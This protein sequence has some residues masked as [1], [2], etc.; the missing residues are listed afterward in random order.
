MEGL[1]D[2]NRR[3]RRIQEGEDRHATGGPEAGHGAPRPAAPGALAEQEEQVAGCDQE[4]KRQRGGPC[5]QVHETD[6]DKT[7]AEPRP[8]A[9]IERGSRPS[10]VERRHHEGRERPQDISPAETRDGQPRGEPVRHEPA[11]ERGAEEQRDTETPHRGEQGHRDGPA[12]RREGNRQR[13]HDPG[14]PRV[15]VPRDERSQGEPG[16]E[17][18]AVAETRG[19][20]QRPAQAS[21]P[22]RPAVHPVRPQA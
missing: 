17:R 2:E 22:T 8:G 19:D 11:P 12:E 9:G 15:T 16:E 21:G 1:D 18:R 3:H 10:G 6:R 4:P 14:E 7:E 20:L 13:Q 5:T